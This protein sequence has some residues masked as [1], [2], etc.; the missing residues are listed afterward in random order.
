MIDGGFML[1]HPLCT[2]FP[3]MERDDMDKLV[4][5]IKARGLQDPIV[6]YQGRI[7]DGQNR[8]HA[9]EL[10]GVEPRYVE[11]EGEDPIGYVCS[12][13]LTRRHL[14][15]SQRALLGMRLT[16]TGGKGS[17]RK[18]VTQIEAAKAVNVSDRSIRN[19]KAVVD[20]GDEELIA[21]VE[22]GE[23]PVRTAAKIAKLSPEKRTVILQDDRPDLAIKK[24][25]RADKEREIA[26]K[27]TDLPDDQFG[28]ILA[29]PPWK[30]VTY[31]ENGM[32]RAPE[33]HYPTLETN[34][35]ADLDVE[36]IAADDSILF[37]WATAPMLRDALAVMKAWGFTYKTHFIWVKDRQGTGYWSRN[38][39]ELLLIGTRGDIPAPSMG[40]QWPSVVD[41]PLG[42]HSAKPEI[43]FEMI[44]SYF[45]TLPKIELNRRGEARPG[46][47]AFGPEAE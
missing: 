37:L 45:P 28:V 32:D 39:H 5:D 27:I 40:S 35:I 38:V 9:C 26:A 16:Q 7:L 41:A 29:D 4:A 42:V 36:S 22:S 46:W 47:A 43:F 31:S 20:S 21:R 34:Q 11:Y 3:L 2:M 13:N 15:E 8:L 25:A 18:K 1:L 6:T 19:A 23:I 10:A 24:V 30:F 33:N 17:R 12:K 14:N 44:E